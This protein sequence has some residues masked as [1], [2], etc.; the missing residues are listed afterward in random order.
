MLSLTFPL[1]LLL[2]TAS[3]LPPAPERAPMQQAPDTFRALFATTKGSF[4]LSIVRSWSPLGAD[5]L[6]TLLNEGHYNGVRLSRVVPGFVVQFGLSSD[7]SENRRWAMRTLPDEPALQD[8][9]LGRVAFA[10]SGPNSRSTQLYI[11][12]GD[13]RWLDGLKNEFLTPIGS[14]EDGMSVRRHT[15]PRTPVAQTLPGLARTTVHRGC[16]QVLSSLYGGYG[17]AIDQAQLAAGGEAYAAKTY[18]LLDRVLMALPVEHGHRG[19][20]VELLERTRANHHSLVLPSDQLVAELARR[21]EPHPEGSAP[22]AAAAAATGAAAA[23]GGVRTGGGAPSRRSSR[24]GSSGSSGSSSKEVDAAEPRERVGDQASTGGSEPTMASALAGDV[25]AEA[26]SG[27]EQRQSATAQQQQ[28][29]PIALVESAS[30]TQAPVPPQRG[31]SQ[32]GDEHEPP[33]ARSHGRG[34][35]AAV[36]RAM[37]AGRTLMPPSVVHPSVGPM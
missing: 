14:V 3:A 21:A 27:A 32:G 17:D 11:N 20:P 18:P 16:A 31:S 35:R 33:S 22:A 6:W 37:G 13:N 9:R 30:S 24:S 23:S 26:P 25:P 28:Q 1:A 12:L 8:N 2:A 7:P 4:I 36:S 15:A 5:R 10:T 34:W 19:A 29:Q